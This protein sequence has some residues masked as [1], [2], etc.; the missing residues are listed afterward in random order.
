MLISTGRALAMTATLAL[1]ATTGQ[2][3]TARPSSSGVLMLGTGN[4]MPDPDRFGPATAVIADSAAYLVD[5]GDGVMRRW[6]AAQAQHLVDGVTLHRIVFLTHLHSDHTQGLPALIWWLWMT[7]QDQPITIYGPRGTRAM[8]G[9]ILAAWSED[10]AIRIGEGG[11]FAG[12]PGPNVKVHEIDPGIVYQDSLVTVTAFAVHHGTWPQAFGYRFNMPDKVI[13][14]SGD[15]AP[16]SAIPG[17]C[18]QCDILV[19]EGG[20]PEAKATSYYHAFHST[21]EEIARVANATHPRLLV[22]THQRPGVNQP[23]LDIIR[24]NYAGRVVIASDLDV[25][26]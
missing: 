11:E 13:V 18:R 5:A 7:D 15:A 25:Y 16:P 23:G 19:H 2:A 9:H 12:K 17:Q 8:T 4:P 6:R 26:H 22:L 20:L 1:I 10:I 3:Q 21:A 24:A 14:I